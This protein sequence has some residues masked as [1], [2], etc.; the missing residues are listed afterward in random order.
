MFCTA[1]ASRSLVWQSREHRLR[2]VFLGALVALELHVAHSCVTHH[3]S[4][5]QQFA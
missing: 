3:Q 2:M 1:C 5:P 4:L